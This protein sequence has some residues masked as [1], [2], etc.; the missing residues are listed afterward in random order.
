[1]SDSKFGRIQSQGKSVAGWLVGGCTGWSRYA[2]CY[3]ERGGTPANVERG[4]T[5]AWAVWGI[6]LADTRLGWDQPSSYK[7]CVAKHSLGAMLGM[8]TRRSVHYVTASAALSEGCSS[9]LQ[10]QQDF[11][12]FT[13]KLLSDLKPRVEIE[14]KTLLGLSQNTKRKVLAL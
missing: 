14:T 1:M 5:P 9:N 12:I 4:V 10:R 7:H 8:F 11:L 2:P 13:L 3:V 6:H